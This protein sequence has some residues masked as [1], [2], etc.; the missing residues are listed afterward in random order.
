LK[1]KKSLTGRLFIYLCK[2]TA[3]KRTNV[4]Q[5]VNELPK[6]FSLDELME[7]LLV[8]E[9]IDKGLQDVKERKTVSHSKAKKEIDKWLK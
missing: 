9:K 4:L 2:K 3:M 7:R 8:I 1:I 5:V 6:E